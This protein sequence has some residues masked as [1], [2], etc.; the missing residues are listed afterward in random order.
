MPKRFTLL[1]L[2]VVCLSLAGCKKDAQ[3]NAVVAELDSFTTELVKKVE[4]APNPAA[5]VDDAQKF[6]DSKK[7]DLTAKIGT[8]KSIRGYQ[9]SEETTKK[10]T[11][12]MVDDAKK[13]A[14]LQIKYI[15]TSMRDPV[16]KGKLEKLTRDYQALF[17]M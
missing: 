9:V 11:T 2:L 6:F 10:M 5:G 1:L 15:G 13:V 12:S 8:L 7:A 17:M 16:F 3:I 4:S 14:G